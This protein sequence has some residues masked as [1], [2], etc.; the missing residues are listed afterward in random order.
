MINKK[1]VI[2]IVFGLLL[3]VINL[4]SPI[5]EAQV[6]ENQYGRLEV[7]P[8]IDVNA[9]R[10]E[11]YFNFTWYKENSSIDIAF[12]FDYKLKN[13]D[14]FLWKN[15]SHDIKKYAYG[16]LSYNETFYNLGS[17]TKLDQA[18][19]D[20][21][22]GDLESDFFY[23][24]N[25][26]NRD[27]DYLDA[28]VGFDSFEWN[29]PQH[30]N[31]TIFFDVYD[32]I[33]TSYIQKSFFDYKSV[34]KHFNYTVYN[35]RHIYYVT[36]NAIQNKTLLG[37]WNYRTPINTVGKWDLFAKYSDES[38]SYAYSNNRY[39]L[40]DPW[41]NSTFFYRKTITIDSS[42]INENLINFPVMVKNSSDDFSS[43]AQTNGDD[44]VFVALDNVTQ[45][46]H[47]IERYNSTTGELIAWV[48]ITNVSADTDTRFNLYYGNPSCASQQDI[49]GTW[50]NSY[51]CVLHMDDTNSTVWDSTKWGH[52]FDSQGNY[53]RVDGFFSYGIHY[54]GMDGDGAKSR[55]YFKP[56]EHPEI[57]VANIT[58]EY[59]WFYYSE[60]SEHGGDVI[61]GQSQ[62]LDSRYFCNVRDTDNLLQERAYFQAPDSNRYYFEYP[63]VGNWYY[64]AWSYD[65]DSYLYSTHWSYAMHNGIVHDSSPNHNNGLDGYFRICLCANY[66]LNAYEGNITLDEVRVSYSERSPNWTNASYQN[67]WNLSLFLTIGE[68]VDNVTYTG[69]ILSIYPLN[70]SVDLC[71]F[72]IF[73]N[74]TVS[75]PEGLL[76]DI[77][78]EHN[79]TGTWDKIDDFYNVINGSY[80]LVINN[81]TKF[82]TT[83]WLRITV[84]NFNDYNF[85]NS[86][87]L[88]YIT[89]D[90]V[91]CSSGGGGGGNLT[92]QDFYDLF[93][94]GAGLAFDAD[95]LAFIFIICFIGIFAYIAE[96][97]KRDQ[98]FRRGSYL[99]VLAI[100][101]LFTTAYYADK[102][103]WFIPLALGLLD[104]FYWIRAGAN[105]GMARKSKIE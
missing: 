4:I 27:I 39:I 31:I 19:D 102:T 95:Q 35:N 18:P 72:C 6:W 89:T 59:I 47:E 71:P 103:L 84:Y 66:N 48:N 49:P 62:G 88:K 97:Q 68:E 100:I 20:V 52:H 28:I 51:F 61:I 70:N 104:A 53:E 21:E 65:N 96:T 69:S 41:F 54:F 56:V 57:Q 25:F 24:G 29:N 30:T 92:Q 78:L 38:F 93:T 67:I 40:L 60:N 98:Y 1:W 94:A 11:Q 82:L 45:Y 46:S 34:K 26:S 7:W 85:S 42:F 83:Y 23:I 105:L 55:D 16:N 91:N 14:I 86:T 64:G 2:L 79:K 81:F 33:G 13:P 75:H 101:L 5:S 99:L 43:H 77:I 37:K 63:S 3:N 87:T 58:F 73:V 74:I 10:H 32:I 44:F 15:Y 22:F 12:I 36:Y 76:M 50:G 17:F 8:D 90:N 80:A 9:C